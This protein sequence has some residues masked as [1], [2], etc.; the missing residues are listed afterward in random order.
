VN[1][2]ESCNQRKQIKIINL[3]YIRRQCIP[4]V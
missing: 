4:N 2:D 1:S 3:T